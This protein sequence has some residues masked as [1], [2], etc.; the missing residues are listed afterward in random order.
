MGLLV[1]VRL[2]LLP[3]RQSHYALRDLDLPEAVTATGQG[4]QSAPVIT[5]L[6]AAVVSHPAWSMS[7]FHG[8]PRVIPAAVT[9][10]PML[11][12]RLGPSPLQR[13]HHGHRTD[14]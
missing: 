6:C 11:A 4:R 3:G 12:A 13:E 10:T 1:A 2:A 14:R 8:Q 7:A 5:A 9:R